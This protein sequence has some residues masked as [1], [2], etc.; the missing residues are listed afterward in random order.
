[1]NREGVGEHGSKPLIPLIDIAASGNSG[2]STTPPQPVRT[3]PNQTDAGRLVARLAFNKPPSFYRLALQSRQLCALRL[4][5]KHVY[6][7]CHF[8][9]FHR[10]RVG[11]QNSGVTL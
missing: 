1:M 3:L 10:G 9:A 8:Y 4:T 2:K 11:T 5:G 7:R 6:E